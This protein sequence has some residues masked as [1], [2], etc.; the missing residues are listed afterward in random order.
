L[1]AEPKHVQ[2]MELMWRDL[3]LQST[4]CRPNWKRIFREMFSGLRHL[5][6]TRYNNLDN[7]DQ[8]FYVSPCHYI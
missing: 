8:M 5:E 1:P 2:T 7:S 3:W 6:R 4:V